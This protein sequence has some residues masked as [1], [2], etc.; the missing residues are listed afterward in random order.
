MIDYLYKGKTINSEYYYSLLDQQDE[1][2]RKKVPDFQHKKIIFH[3]D[4]APAYKGVLTMIKFNE[5][6]YDL[7]EHPP[8]SPDLSPSAE[9]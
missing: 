3:Q 1:K 4:N 5:L 9:T 7:P 6:K 2:L 8:Y